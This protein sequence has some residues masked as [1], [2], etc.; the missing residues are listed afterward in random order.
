MNLQATREGKRF[1]LAVL[2]V[3]FAALNTGN[4]LMYLIFSMLFSV[5]L[6]SIV[7]PYL[8]LRSIEADLD[9]QEPIYARTKVPLMIRIR[10]NK[11]LLPSYSVRLTIPEIA[12][13][14]IYFDVLRP[15]EQR[16]IT[17]KVTFESRGYFSLTDAWLSTSFPFIFFT[18]K[19]SPENRKTILVYPGIK[20]LTEDI[21]PAQVTDS[22]S[23]GFRRAEA[24]E[25]GTLREYQRGDSL[26]SIHWKV[27]AKKGKLMVREL[28]EQMP[29]RITILLDNTSHRRA[30]DF[31]KAVT[32]TASL[33]WLYIK[34]GYPVRLITCRKTIPFGTGMEHL[35]KILDLLAVIKMEETVD[36]RT[37]DLNR[38]ALILILSSES[39]IFRR[40]GSEANRVYYASRL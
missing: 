37:E 33:S 12:A 25:A 26:K 22:Q 19:K 40:F 20:D 14:G 27:T 38:G 10:N 4:N 23:A 11:K 30:D 7:L 5:L 35:Y 6:I 39:S 21:L 36:C 29:R 8:N 24:D 18:L 34:Q 16:K 9:I 1:L 17:R 31:E 28:Y 2:V 15:A 32:L 13:G 3:G